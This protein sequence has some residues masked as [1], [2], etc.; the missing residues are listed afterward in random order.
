M[1]G[2]SLVDSDTM[3][4]GAEVCRTRLEG[5][6]FQVVVLNKQDSSYGMFGPIEVYVPSIDLDRAK[7]FVSAPDEGE[8]PA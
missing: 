5:A 1:E 3:P 4:F 2:W 8:N 7:A 6:G